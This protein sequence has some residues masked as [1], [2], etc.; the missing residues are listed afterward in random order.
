MIPRSLHRHIVQRLHAM[1]GVV[2]F[3]P[4]QVG[5]TT[6]A[7]AI[8]S[9]WGLRAEYLDLERERDRRRLDD[10]DA[11]LRRQRG[12]LVVL[13]EVHR[14]PGLFPTLRS[15]IDA[16]RAE[17]DRTGQF[18]LLGSASLD[19]QRQAGESLAGRVSY[20]ELSPVL[21]SE[22][23]VPGRPDATVDRLWVRG[24]FPDS[25]LADTDALSLAWREDFVRSYLERD[26]PQFAP[27]TSPTAIGRLWRM[28]A[29]AQGTPLNKARLA[30]NL[31]V[32]SPTITAYLDLLGDLLL[33]RQ[34]PP[35]SGN[36]SKRLVRTPKVYLRDSGLVHA[37]LGLA[38]LDDVLS[39]P[40][41]GASWEGFVIEQLI[42]AAGP[43][44][45]AMYFRT[46]AGA[47]ADLVFERGGRVE[48]VIEVKRSSAPT[49]SSGLRVACADLQ[50]AHAFVVHGGEGEWPMRDSVTA[51]GVRELVQPL[52]ADAPPADHRPAAPS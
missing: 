24:G 5:K 20:L 30:G 8:V 45:Q 41:V 1:P 10:A 13:D 17:G 7:R 22:Y 6:L 3:G 35:W 18:L 19:L 9:E 2:L 37:L 15:V 46:A 44:R 21:A 39:H 51:I 4:R 48:M 50:P 27:R 28:L 33:V 23:V 52:P 32:S 38:T 47:E 11:W 49:V 40:V 29:H 25:L 26:I 31:E 14:M 16:R 43:Q 36:L 42:A 12:R 34:L